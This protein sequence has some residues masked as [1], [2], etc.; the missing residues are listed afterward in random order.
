MSYQSPSLPKSGT[1]DQNG[2]SPVRKCIA[3]S[4]LQ[5]GKQLR[6]LLA[7][8]H[9]HQV[10]RSGV[11]M[12]TRQSSSLTQ[13]GLGQPARSPFV[14]QLWLLLPHP[15]PV[16]P[17]SWPLGFRQVLL[18]MVGIMS[19]PVLP[20]GAIWKSGVVERFTDEPSEPLHVALV[21]G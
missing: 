11:G 8:P 21:H 7:F 14:G 4:I 9:V 6:E 19:Q 2:Q 20:Q 12:E 1:W 3:T 18:A 17:G 13:R 15:Q 5:L 10:L 16:L